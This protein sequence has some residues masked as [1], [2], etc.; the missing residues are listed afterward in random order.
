MSG[1]QSCVALFSRATNPT[2]K[3]KL[4]PQWCFVLL[5]SQTQ[6]VERGKKDHSKADIK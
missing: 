5:I 3:F 6:S 1:F 2:A 4:Y